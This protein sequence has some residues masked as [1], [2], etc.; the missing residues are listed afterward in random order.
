MLRQVYV[1]SL[2]VNFYV[3]F[4]C[5]GFCY[6]FGSF[7]IYFGPLLESKMSSKSQKVMPK[8]CS[9]WG[10]GS[11]AK[12]HRKSDPPD[13]RKVGSRLGAVAFFTFSLLLQKVT[14]KV[15]KSSPNGGPRLSKSSPERVLKMCWNFNWFLI[16]FCPKMESKWSPKSPKVAQV[17]L[18]LGPN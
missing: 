8:W 4:F 5:I 10:L 17:A 14:K 9:K 18:K 7:F 15:P 13:L 1:L 12:K 6:L 3:T 2:L 16:A 11:G